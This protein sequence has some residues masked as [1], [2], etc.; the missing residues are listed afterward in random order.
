[1]PVSG[2]S[3]DPIISPET[4]S[5]AQPIDKKASLEEKPV[6]DIP[7]FELDQDADYTFL[8]I[9]PARRARA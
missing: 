2:L 6:Q 3:P 8:T 5:A 1:M 7:Y 9:K 4:P